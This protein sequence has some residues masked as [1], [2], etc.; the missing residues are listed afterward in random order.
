MKAIRKALGTVELRR[1]L[2]PP[3]AATLLSGAGTIVTIWAVTPRNYWVLSI[4]AGVFLL[5]LVWIA[6]PFLTAWMLPYTDFWLSWKGAA[7]WLKPKLV[8]KR[9][10]LIHAYG[11]ETIATIGVA[12]TDIGH[13]F[14]EI[15]Q[16][17]ASGVSF[18]VFMVNPDNSALM[19]TLK[20][21]ES[22]TKQIKEV[23]QEPVSKKLAKLAGRDEAAGNAKRA[24][25]LRSLAGRLEAEGYCDHSE[26]IRVCEE[27]WLLAGAAGREATL[28]P[29][30]TIQ[31]YRMDEL[32]F[33]RQWVIGDKALLYSTYP[34]H[35]GV[36]TDN[37]VFCHSAIDGK[38][39][40]SVAIAER[41]ELYVEQLTNKWDPPYKTI[42]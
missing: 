2:L 3:L 9:R 12:C 30:A 37:P 41:A 13:L 31:I 27:L 40:G 6:V 14:D 33:A 5:S 23:V 25:T 32:P 21:L 4:F 29:S 1:D 24:Q 7:K 42:P 17:V 28:H 38:V 19:D 36:G 22:N 15:V 8:G 34:G 18:K 26:C 10:H 39:E 20:K 35:P 11:V 16:A